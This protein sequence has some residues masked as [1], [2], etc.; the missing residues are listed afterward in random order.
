MVE[1]NIY[2]DQSSDVSKIFF[3]KKY[4]EKNTC[5]SQQ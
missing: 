3:V 4:G 2:N 5:A 1:S